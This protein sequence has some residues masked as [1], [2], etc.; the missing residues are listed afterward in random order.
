MK[1]KLLSGNPFAPEQ[2]FAKF[3]KNLHGNFRDSLED[4]QVPTCLKGSVGEMRGTE[5]EIHG[6][7][8]RVIQGD[9]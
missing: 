8:V 2:S 5:Q 9:V 4:G 1:M 7:N 6:V 3:P